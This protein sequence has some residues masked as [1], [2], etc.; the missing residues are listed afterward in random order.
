MSWVILALLAA[1]VISIANISDKTV[2]HRYVKHP[3][4][5]PLLI[6]MV[7]TLSGILSFIIAGI[8]GTVT[9]ETTTAALVSG[10]LWGISGTIMIR[11]LFT[12][13]VSRT[14]PV[15]QSS[16][17]FAALLSMVFL[18]EH[19]SHMQWAGIVLTVGGSI[20]ISLHVRDV[21]T[22][23]LHKSFYLLMFSAL[24]AGISTIIGKYVLDELPILY[25]HALRMLGLGG[26]FLIFALRSPS[27]K[28]VQGFFIN[29]SPA[30]IFV[31]VNEFITANVAFLLL[32]W[33]LSE[34]PASLVIALM[35]TRSLFVILY[36]TAITFIWQGSLGEQVSLNTVF[37]KV[38]SV[39]LIVAGIAGIAI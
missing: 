3:L 6:G 37:L 22:I 15:T 21:R 20:I 28:E 38:V 7:G 17:I 27:W 8:P 39:A 23:F 34:G 12:Q 35:G 1:A 11:V 26:V 13:E 5:Y 31:G 29:R 30:L 19:I 16:P 14:I 9:V 2:I 4:T 33:A 32:L 18:G 24:A 10:A 25:T 36:S